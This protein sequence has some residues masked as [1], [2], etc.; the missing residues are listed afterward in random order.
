VKKITDG[1]TKICVFSA[2]L[3]AISLFFIT[4]ATVTDVVLRAFFSTGLVGATEIATAFLTAVVYFGVGYCTIKRGMITVELIKVPPAVEY[5]NQIL[6]MIMGGVIICA[7]TTQAA[8]SHA[9]GVGSLRL[10]IPKWPFMLIT[11]FGYLMM[12]C[13][14]LINMCGDIRDRRAARRAPAVSAPQPF[15]EGGRTE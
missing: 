5:V 14:M 7:V 2:I 3:G 11:S 6:C 9:T 1:F 10:G 15:A 8:F 12:I 4:M 13:A